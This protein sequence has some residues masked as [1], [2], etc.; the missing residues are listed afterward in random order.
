MRGLDTNVLVRYLTADEP[1]QLALAQCVLE[2]SERDR[3]PV[4]LPVIVLCEL[5]W[6]LS[7]AYDHKKAAIA[8]ALEHLL[9]VD[10]FQVEHDVLVRRSLDAYRNGA[11]SFSD[12][13][14]GEISLHYGCRDVVTF[15]RALKG[16]RGFSVLG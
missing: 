2:E 15:D 3:E 7:R 12:Y 8:N 5:V 14:I 6:V 9:E 1:R 10:R 4:F 11:G 16:V 13:L